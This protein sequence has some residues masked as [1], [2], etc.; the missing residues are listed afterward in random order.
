MLPALH[1][2]GIKNMI[3]NKNKT[4]QVRCPDIEGP[5]HS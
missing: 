3:K 2:N 1:P 4:Q 5:T